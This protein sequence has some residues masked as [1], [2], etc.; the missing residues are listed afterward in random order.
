MTHYTLKNLATGREFDD[1]GWL[2]N[3]PEYDKPSLIRSVYKEKKLNP[4]SDSLGIY[5]FSNWLPVSRHFREAPVTVTYKSSAL[6]DYLGLKQLYVAFSGYWPERDAFMTTCSFKETEAYSVC[7]RLSENN[8]R[9]LV[10]ASAG[11]TARAFAKVCSQN[12]IPLLLVV[13]YENRDAMWFGERLSECVKLVCTPE[14]TDYYDAID[15]SV[16]ICKSNKFIEEGGARNVARRDGMGTTVLSAALSIGEIPDYYFQAIGSGTGTIA[17]WEA[18]LRLIEDGGFGNKKMVLMPSQ[19][20]PFTP[21]YDAWCQDKREILFENEDIARQNALK[22]GARVLSNRKPPYAVTG[23]L[24][25]ALKDSK[26]SIEIASNIEMRN[27][28]ALFEATEGIDINPAAGIALAG[29]IKSI[30]R[31]PV[32]K[33]KILMLNITGGGEK[34]AR[35]EVGEIL[36]KPDIIINNNLNISEIMYKAEALF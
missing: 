6:A 35:K 17:A 25:D 32:I 4:G 7:A 20:I 28:C 5:K 16:K 23:G 19:N 11:N 21:M 14:G 30:E 9:V 10:V 29:M 33:D 27:A 22:I 12:N 8:K 31:E 26:G 24:Y 2:L 36:H 15:L 34:R 13:P 3:D 18:N 1:T